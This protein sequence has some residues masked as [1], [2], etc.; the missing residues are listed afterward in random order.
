MMSTVKSALGIL[1]LALLALLLVM[2]VGFAT[3][4]DA[5]TRVLYGVTPTPAAP[6][7]TPEPTPTNTPEPIPTNTPAPTNTA[8]PP[9]PNPT[10]VPAPTETPIPMLPVSGAER[11]AGLLLPAVLVLAVLA[12]LTCVVAARRIRL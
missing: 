11:P 5:Q 1:L 10:A 6:T 8:R 9:S 4:A 2:M 12:L 3:P 7:D